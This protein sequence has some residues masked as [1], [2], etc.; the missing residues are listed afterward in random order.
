[1]AMDHVFNKRA[2]FAGCARNCAE[3]LPGVLGNVSQLSG[4]FADSAFIFIENDSADATKS[5]IELWCRGKSNARLISLD[6][7]AKSYPPRTLRLAVARNRYLSTVQSDFQTYDY[8]IV[9]DCDEVNA[10]P[11]DLQ[12]ARRAIEFLVSD[13]NTAA[14]FPNPDG[15]YYDLWALRH[16]AQCPGDVWEEVCD[17]AVSHGV[18]DEEAFRRTFSKR[19]F[20]I[21]R[22]APT[23]LEVDSAFGGLGIYKIQSLLRNKRQYVGHKLKFIA[24]PAAPRANDAG[25]RQIGWQCCEHVSF[26][27]G[28]RELGEKLF[29]L[30]YFTNFRSP[31]TGFPPSFWRTLPFDPRLASGQNSAPESSPAPGKIGRN[32]PCPCGSGKKYKH[33]HGAQA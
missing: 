21:P 29:V 5:E 1:M 28:F 25:A 19:I 10:A 9:L 6:G 2:V 7:L 4:L 30:P 31:E 16:P 13:V 20:T 3:A 8:L 27:A 17:Y 24:P 23:P 11:I 15:V 26:N 22:D 18:T 33:C 32:Q 14:V 12:A